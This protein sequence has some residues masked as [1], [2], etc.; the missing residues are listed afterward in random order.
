MKKKHN[1]QSL[2]IVYSTRISNPSYQEMLRNKFNLKDIEIIEYVNNNEFSLTEL[3]N[4]GLKESS[5]NIVVF[6]HDDLEFNNDNIGKKL[7]NHFNESDYGILGIAGTTDL[8][9][10]RWWE[11]QNRMVGIVNHKKDGKKWESKYS[12]NFENK[13]IPLVTVDGLFFAVDKTKIYSEFDEDFKGFHFYDISFCISNHLKGV[14][15][16][17]IF[18]VKVTHLSIGETND[19][20]ESNKVLFEDKFK[21]SLPINLKVDSLIYNN[22]KFTIKPNKQPRL[23]IIILHKEKNDLLFQC[24]DTFLL[25]TSYE[26]Y[27]IIIGDT[28]SSELKKNEIRDKY[29]SL[30]DNDKLELIEFSSYDYSKNTN[31]IVDSLSDEFECLLF[32]NNDIKFIEDNDCVSKMVLSYL[33]NPRGC[34]TIGARLHYENNSVQ[35]GS[36]VAYIINNQFRVTH[37]SLGSYYKY[38]DNVKRD[39]F[40]NTFACALVSRKL[41]NKIGGLSLKYITCFQDVEFSCECIKQGKVNIFNGD[42]VAY[43]LESQSRS[44]NEETNAK[45]NED[46][47][48]NLLPYIQNNFEYIKKNVL[49]V[50][51]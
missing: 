30:I 21:E 46:M 22:K 15:I 23:A 37:D 14:K 32:L 3:Y 41:F 28:G 18:D 1:M 38:I 10:G 47:V 36:I 51:N 12:N 39:V 42:A 13:I 25:S 24:I 17:C 40:G 16:G 5:N 45:E 6:L 43:H 11:A 9:S 19:N 31:D 33:D 34:G 26:N 27:K 44:K 29:F 50:N 7:L 8:V 49:I 48:N 4:K 2:S 20:W 35:H